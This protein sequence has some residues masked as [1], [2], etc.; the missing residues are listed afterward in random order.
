MLQ[1]IDNT[2]NRETSSHLFNQFHD[3]SVNKFGI[4]CA[5][6]IK[7]ICSHFKHVE[8]LVYVQIKNAPKLR[9]QWKE[10]LP[11]KKEQAFV[12]RKKNWKFGLVK[13]TNI[14]FTLDAKTA[15]RLIS[16]T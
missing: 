4:Q 3:G 7:T 13:D 1:I 5:Y 9:E 14:T 12:V 10:S 11:V 15:Q 2:L 6:L 8:T 16:C